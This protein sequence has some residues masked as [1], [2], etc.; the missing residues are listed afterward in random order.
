MEDRFLAALLGVAVGDALGFPFEGLPREALEEIDLSHYHAGLFPPGTWSDDTSLTFLTAESLLNK[1]GL[2]LQDLG[3]RFLRWLKEGYLTPFGQA[4][5]VGRATKEALKRLARG[6]PPERAGG[7]GERDNGNGALMRILPV[8]LW[9]LP[10]EGPKF[11]E[12]IH[13][14]AALTHAHPRNLLACGLYGLWVKG[15][16]TGKDLAKALED[17][18][19][20]AQI[21]Y[22]KGPFIEEWKH[23]QRLK[24][25]SSLEMAEIRAS[26]YVVHSLEAVCWVLLKAS[27][28]RQALTLA[29][30]LGEDTDTTAAITGGVASL[31]YGAHA[32]PPEWVQGLIKG[33]ELKAR[34]Q[35]FATVLS[36]LHAG[37]NA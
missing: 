29:V 26:G 2:D 3:Q 11:L 17:A 31:Y 1:R 19:L 23:F 35:R 15:I 4:I 25:I 6:V 10:A 21:F 27:S 22:R 16:W 8:V 5:G 34:A 7:R 28:F 30:Q 36:T 12:P 24:E 9:Y 13:Q 33:E 20:Q 14:A 32:L 18:L 37:D